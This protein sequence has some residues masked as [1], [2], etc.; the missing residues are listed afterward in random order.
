MKD[1]DIV[2]VEYTGRYEDRD[3]KRYFATPQGFLM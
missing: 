1:F 3:G 2:K